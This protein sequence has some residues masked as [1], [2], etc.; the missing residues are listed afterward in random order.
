M[1]S[2]HAGVIVLVN[3]SYS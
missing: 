1:I 2:G 3:H